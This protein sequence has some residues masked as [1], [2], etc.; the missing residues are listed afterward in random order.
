MAEFVDGYF[1]HGPLFFFLP[2]IADLFNGVL[3]L[4]GLLC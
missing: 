3:K 1:I 2:Y 4:R